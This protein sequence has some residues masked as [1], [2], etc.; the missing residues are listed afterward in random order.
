MKK[1]DHSDIVKITRPRVSGVAPRERLFRELDRGR[2][3]PV[4]W[5]A[6]LAGSG[7]TTL[8]ASWLDSRKLPCLWY[9][10]DAG[11]GDLASFFYYLGMAAQKAAPRYKSPLPLLTPEYLPGALLFARRYFEELFRRLKAPFVVIFDNYQDIQRDA[12]FQEMFLHALETVPEGIRVIVLSRNDPPQQLA[13]LQANNRLQF[14]GWD[15]VRFTLAESEE[16]LRSQS[17]VQPDRKHAALLHEKTDGWA[18]GLV[19]LMSGPKSEEGEPRKGL[20]LSAERVFDYFAWEVFEK[21]DNEQRDFLLTASFLPRMTAEAAERFTGYREAGRILARLNRQHFFIQKHGAAAAVFQF[22]PLFRNFLQ[23]R[24]RHSQ[25]NDSILRLQRRAAVLLAQEGQTEDAIAFFL[26]AADWEGALELILKTAK[27]LVSQCRYRALSA[28]L[29]SLPAVLRDQSGWALYWLGVCRMYRDP[30]EG[31]AQLVLAFERFKA[32]GER[33]GCFLAWIRIQE[34]IFFAWGENRKPWIGELQALRAGDA[35]FPSP[36]IEA[37]VSLHMF[38]AAMTG[39]SSLVHEWEARVTEIV[40]HSPVPALRL[41][42][43]HFLMIFHLWRGDFAKAGAILSAVPPP[44]GR[45]EDNTPSHLTWDAMRAMYAWWSADAET[46]FAA[47]EEGLDLAD[48]TGVHI[49]DAYLYKYGVSAAVSLGRPERAVAL[50]QRMSARPR[51]STMDRSFYHYLTALVSWSEGEAKKAVVD[52]SVALEIVDPLEHQIPRFCCHLMQTVALYDA[53]ERDEA[54]HYLVRAW[55]IAA[56]GTFVEYVAGL[57]RASYAL[58]EHRRHDGLAA[59]RNAMALGAAQGYM[60]FGWWRPTMMS[61]L[62]AIALEEGIETDYARMLVRRRQLTP[63]GD[64][65]GMHAWPYPVRIF[66]LGRFQILKDDEAVTFPG[67]MPKKPLELLKALIAFGGVDVPEER[68]LEALWPDADGDTGHRSFE[69]T[70]YR[71]RKLVGE[72]V[73]RLQNGLVTLDRRYCSVDAW[74]FARLAQEGLRI[75]GSSTGAPDAPSP[76]EKAL[77]LYLGQFLPADS[78]QPWSLLLR[79]RLKNDYIN[80]V[81]GMGLFW[82]RAGAWDRAASCFRKGLEAEEHAEEFYRHLMRCHMELGQRSQAEAVYRNC[83]AVLARTLGIT[84]SLQTE[85]LYASLRAER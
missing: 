77:A 72:N 70:L 80:L 46:C 73:V 36:E 78:V 82:E 14:I 11:D 76:V 34:T 62:C 53:G 3:M 23:V 59:L 64:L 9:Q 75:V 12:P 51:I 83:R 65:A 63:P 84:P 2:T 19:L 30:Y 52:S 15:A 61:R 39:I 21:L 10:V 8:I 25:D 29:E 44:Q 43:G 16:L 1:K 35:T 42:L 41:Q 28:W 24:M 31:R 6:S 50:L 56:G 57:F 85:E 37:Q 13:K 49:L 54:Q 71:L 38:L 66:T 55:E 40:F 45:P 68:F 32:T 5:V 4:T 69:T 48:A 22:H 33:T 7:K 27:V 17:A 79:E 60:N 18:A 74:D 47:V 67:K 81:T 20:E 58:E 26:G